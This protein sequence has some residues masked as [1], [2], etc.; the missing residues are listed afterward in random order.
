MLIRRDLE[1]KQSRDSR[2]SKVG[3][4][5]GLISSTKIDSTDLYARGERGSAAFS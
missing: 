1:M 5:I 2:Q 4:R 3:S